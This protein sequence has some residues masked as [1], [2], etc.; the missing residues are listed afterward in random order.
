MGVYRGQWTT[1]DIH[2]IE[3]ARNDII[4]NTA[5][6]AE[7]GIVEAHMLNN[8]KT[9]SVLVKFSISGCTRFS[10]YSLRRGRMLIGP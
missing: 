6:H 10:M 5:E 8:A 9:S 3:I 4:I 1:A 7:R 2:V